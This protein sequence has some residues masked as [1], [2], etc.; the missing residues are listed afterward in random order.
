MLQ[1]SGNENFGSPSPY[2]TS[3]ALSPTFVGSVNVI[4][5]SA[6]FCKHISFNFIWQA[7]QTKFDDDNY[8]DKVYF[9]FF[10]D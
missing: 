1:D 10:L 9:N 6:P 4:Y 8:R 3:F 7:A 2:Q 5:S